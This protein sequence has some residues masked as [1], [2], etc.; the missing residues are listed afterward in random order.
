MPTKRAAR[1]VEKKAPS[2]AEKKK[3][4]LV[5]LKGVLSTS[6]ILET[7]HEW[8]ATGKHRDFITKLLAEAEARRAKA[9]WQGNI[10]KVLRG[11]GI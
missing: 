5:F 3:I 8:E 7:V 6:F 9:E 1:V 11:M 2:A 10:S 4:A